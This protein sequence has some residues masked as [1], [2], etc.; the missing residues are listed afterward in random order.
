MRTIIALL[1][2]ASS[3]QAQVDLKLLHPPP[4][5]LHQLPPPAPAPKVKVLKTIRVDP[6]V[7]VPPR[8]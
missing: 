3:A 4:H 5:V 8:K 2:L 7:W 6:P 1:L